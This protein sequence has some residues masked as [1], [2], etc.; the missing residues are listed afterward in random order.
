MCILLTYG[1]LTA[2]MS[3]KR[4]HLLMRS[5]RFDDATTRQKRAKYDN[6]AP[7]RKIVEEFVKRC[8]NNYSVGE[9]VTI[10]EMLESFRGKCRLRQ[11][12]ANKPVKYGIK[13]YSLVYSR[14]F[15]THNMEIDKSGYCRQLFYFDTACQ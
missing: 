11:Y 7:I 12:I 6:L 5:L 13:I 10:D 15:Y 14:I 2:V 3:Q 9:Y 4:F 8:S 1:V